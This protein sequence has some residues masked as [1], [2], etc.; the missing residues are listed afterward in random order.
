MNHHQHEIV[1]SCVWTALGFAVLCFVLGEITGNV[2]Q[3]DKLWS[4]VPVVYSWIVAGRADFPAR[5]VLMAVLATVWGVRLT[6]N[7]SRHDGYSWRFW[8]G[9]EDYRWVHVREMPVLRTRVGW[10]LF[11]LGFICVIQH[12]LLLWIALPIIDAVDAPH[13]LGVL[14]VLLAVT[15]VA[16]LALETWADQTQW[17]FQSE[18]KRRLAAGE[19]LTDRYVAGFIHD[20]PW[21]YTR[22]PNYLAE[23][24][25]WVVF[26][27]FAVVA[28]HRIDWTIGGVIVLLALF[29]GSSAT[30]ERIQLAK[31]ADYR[32]YQRRTP[33]FLPWPKAALR[34]RRT[35]SL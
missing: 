14:D 26:W 15:F 12:A 21:R 6:Y 7:V 3:V 24:S 19:P 4:I 22:H 16:L 11:D 17:N 2:S 10:T 34:A 20:G 9:V 33:R 23:Q 32:A 13:G 31:Y 25:M 27:L 29:Q 8:S 1:L 30:S 18:K 35:P 28:T 5:A